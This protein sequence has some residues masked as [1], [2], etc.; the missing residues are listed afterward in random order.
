[1]TENE[2]KLIQQIYE[3][4]CSM[5]KTVDRVEDSL[6]RM[7]SKMGHLSGE[8]TSTS[9]EDKLDDV[10]VYTKTYKTL[11]QRDLPMYTRDWLKL[12]K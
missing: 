1:M 4:V 5:E 7:D 9:V 8:E 6:D 2:K 12:K 11:L 10:K 3:K